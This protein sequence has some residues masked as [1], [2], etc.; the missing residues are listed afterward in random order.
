MSFFSTFRGRLFLVLG[1]LL[2]MTTGV[3]YYLNLRTQAENINLTEMRE[4]ALLAGFALGV[5]SMTSQDRLRDFV[6][7]EGQSFYNEKTSKRIK[8]IFVIDADWQVYDSLSGKYLPE[9]S[10]EGDLKTVDLRSIK[11]LPPLMEG[12]EKLG[13][14]INNFPNTGAGADENAEGEAH[15]IPVETN[16]GRFYVMVILEDNKREAVT[17]AAQP[18]IFTIGVFIVAILVTMILVWRFTTP[19]ANL[20]RAARRVAKG[21]LSFRLSESDRSDEIGSLAT[22]FN[23]MTEELEKTRALEEQLR[24]AEKSAVVGRLASAIAHEIR[25]PLN[26]IN[27]TLDHLRN[28][29]RPEEAEKSV[30]FEKL[31]EQ[32]KNEVDRIN[33]LVSDFLRYTRPSN[34]VRQP[35][36]VR[37]V[38]ESS[39]KIIEHQAEE[40]GITVSLVE[41]DSVPE[42]LGDR[43]MLRSV[44]SN[45]LLNALHAMEQTGGRLTITISAS[46]SEVV[47]EVRDTGTG[48]P[49]VD[50]CKVFEPYF[51]TKETGTGLGLAIVKRII[52]EHAGTIELESVPGEG[53]TFTIKLRAALLE[54]PE[55]G[56]RFTDE[57]ECPKDGVELEPSGWG[58]VAPT[59]DPAEQ[60]TV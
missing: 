47:I 36:D 11:D 54:C 39:L 53:T 2:V 30:T 33:R 7:R 8:D 48:I 44:F 59:G 60:K 49:E 40:H 18:L 5:N 37:R 27:L 3:Q 56:E 38:V 20:S 21:D 51:S 43:E 22:Q 12:R 58:A 1:V 29:F 31:T 13:D 26:Y 34:L 25:N 28:R 57:V 46:D 14:D 4:Q 50:A 32:L 35:V 16:Q 23:I 19:I 10:E 45:L 42:V 55:C 41:R 17:R 6:E 9:E 52:E 15:A 24:E